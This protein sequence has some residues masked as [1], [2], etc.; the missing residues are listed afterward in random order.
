[1]VVCDHISAGYGDIFV[2][3]ADRNLIIS[4]YLPSDCPLLLERNNNLHDRSRREGCLCCHWIRI[5][6]FDHRNLDGLPVNLQLVHLEGKAAG[7]PSLKL[8]HKGIP[9]LKC[10]GPG[11]RHRSI[12]STVLCVFSPQPVFRTERKFI[13]LV[14]LYP[15]RLVL[16]H[17]AY[18]VST[19]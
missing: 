12:D 19:V 3:V 9:T 15:D 4:N 11:C 7:R 1:M 6:Q 17:R 5:L 2:A 14:V 10:P 18:L 16:R 8:P 13:H